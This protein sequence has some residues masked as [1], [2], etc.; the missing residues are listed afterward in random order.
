MSFKTNAYADRHNIWEVI[1]AAGVMDN[2]NTST[3]AI[4]KIKN[5]NEQG[6]LV[7]I[8]EGLEQVVGRVFGEGTVNMKILYQDKEALEEMIQTLTELEKLLKIQSNEEELDLVGEL[9][10]GCTQ[11]LEITEIIIKDPD[12]KRMRVPE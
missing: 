9:K 4:I 1:R 2:S 7:A 11:L 10:D 5:N 12:H 6:W 8:T 3:Y